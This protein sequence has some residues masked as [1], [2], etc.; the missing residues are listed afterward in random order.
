MKTFLKTFIVSI[1]FFSLAYSLGGF[2]SIKNN[3]QTQDLKEHIVRQDNLNNSI[4]TKIEETKKQEEFQDLQE[5]LKE[6]NRRNI[7]VLGLEEIRSDVM[8]LASFDKDAQILDVIS[9][10]RDTYIHRKGY[11]SGPERKINAI[12]YSNGIRGV[13]QAGEHILKIP[14]DNHVIIDYKGVSQIV[15]T[16]GGVEVDVPFHMKYDDPT[17]NPP[18][19]IDIK[20]GKQVLDGK[21]SVD[22]IRWRKNN[23]NSINYIDGD[24]GRIKAQHEFLKSLLSKSRNNLIKIASPIYNYLDMDLNILEI[25]MIARD[26]NGIDD[27]NVRFY[28]LPGDHEFRSVDGDLYSYYIYDR[29]EIEKLMEEIYNVKKHP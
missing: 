5:A 8:I 13:K 15:D 20:E 28:T 16:I 10:P 12:Y 21:D 29:E 4:T 22:F 7:L 26:A 24:L 14:I 6:S 17:A 18:L 3:S 9:I 1:L 25:L 11:N 23:N 27:K 2:I 19:H